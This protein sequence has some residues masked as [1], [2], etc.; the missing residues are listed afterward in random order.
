VAVDVAVPVCVGVW[1]TVAVAV[2]VWVTVPVWVAV[3]VAVA[4]CVGVDV[5]VPVWVAVPVA[6][7]VRV[8]VDVAVAVWVAVPV[9][10]A[11]RV[12][13][14]VAVPVWVAVGVGN[15]PCNATAPI[16]QMWDPVPAPASQS[17]VRSHDIVTLAAPASE[18]PA[19]RMLVVTPVVARFQPAGTVCPAPATAAGGL[20]ARLHTVPILSTTTSLVLTPVLTVTVAVVVA[21]PSLPVAEL[22]P[23]NGVV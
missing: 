2:P 14:D 7:A 3:P 4:V 9:D 8:A 15:T 20:T 19:P 16:D 10:V 23:P 21:L 1:V 18:L 6:V 17:P 13:V 11:V 12:A 5:T 22:N